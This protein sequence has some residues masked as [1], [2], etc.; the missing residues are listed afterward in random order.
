MGIDHVLKE[1]RKE[2]QLTQE[3]LAEKIYVTNKTVSN[4]ET[5]KT[6][7]DIDSLIRLANLFDL[8]LDNL[9]LEGSDVVKNIKKQ[10]KLKSLKKY[11]G[12]TVT[13]IFSIMF[14]YI[15]QGIFGE[16]ST[17]VKIALCIGG[18]SNILAI[19]YFMDEINQI[20]NEPE[21]ITN[22]KLKKSI[23]FSLTGIIILV[24]SYFLLTCHL[25]N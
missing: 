9:L 11:Y 1:K 15:T 20:E 7:P 2:Y 10:T 21:N 24:I 18:V 14:I 13:T 3:Q 4:W 23:V 25:A 22:A 6:T 16:L 12:T 19:V 8:S 5:G 17:P